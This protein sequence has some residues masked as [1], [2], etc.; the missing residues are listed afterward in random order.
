MKV[1]GLAHLAHIRYKLIRWPSGHRASSDSGRTRHLARLTA[2][3]SPSRSTIAWT[4]SC[5]AQ[6]TSRYARQCQLHACIILLNDKIYLHLPV[7]RIQMTR[8]SSRLPFI[9]PST[10]R[11]NLSH[12]LVI[13]TVLRAHTATEACRITRRLLTTGAHMHGLTSLTARLA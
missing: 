13:Q 6:A 12:S 3:A 4:F 9:M 2:D 11:Q 5:A 1:A 10:A 8:S 7:A